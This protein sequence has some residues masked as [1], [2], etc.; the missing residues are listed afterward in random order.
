MTTKTPVRPHRPPHRPEENMSFLRFNLPRS[1]AAGSTGR[2]ALLAAFVLGTIGSGLIVTQPAFATPPTDSVLILSTTVS[3]GMSSKEAQTAIDLG[4]GV[5][6]VDATEWAA[7][8][9]SEFASYRAIILGDPDCGYPDTILAEIDATTN[10]WG[11]MIDGNVMIVGTDPV[12]HS[13]DLVTENGIALATA[14]AGPE[15]A[16][17]YTRSPAFSR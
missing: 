15:G 13:K 7:M 5:D 4:F 12:L 3:G 10:V 14:E 8:T 9:S 2:W 17:C 11:P 16:A 1:Q 6:L